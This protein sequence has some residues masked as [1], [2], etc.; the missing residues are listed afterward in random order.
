MPPRLRAHLESVGVAP[1][2]YAASWL[3]TTFSAEYPASFSAR[4]MDVVLSEKV[5]Q[6]LLK[7]A[8]ALLTA[9]E[10]ALLAAGD[11]EEALTFIKQ[12][13]P[14]WDEATLHDVLSEAF[15]KPWLPR[16]L[17][18]LATWEG[19]ETVGEAAERIGRANEAAAAAAA[20]E[21]GGGGGGGGGSGAGSPKQRLSDGGAPSPLPL[22]PPPCSPAAGL[23]SVGSASMRA[24]R[25]LSG[26]GA[27]SAGDGAA[28]SSS[29]ALPSPLAPAPATPPAPAAAA[30]GTAGAAAA[31][32]G[33]WLGGWEPFGEAPPSPSPQ[34][35]PAAA[36]PE[37]LWHEER[38]QHHHQHQHQHHLPAHSHGPSGL[39]PSASAPAI[40]GAAAAPAA[41]RA[42]AAAAARPA[43]VEPAAAGDCWG[44]FLS[45]PHVGLSD[46]APHPAAAAGP[47]SEWQ[48]EWEQAAP[49]AAAAAAP[50]SVPPQ[51]QQ[52]QQHQHQ[53]QRQ[54][55][56]QKTQQQAAADSLFEGL[57]VA[58]MADSSPG[59]K[60]ADLLL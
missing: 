17:A 9:G 7:V 13:M 12:G 23:R 49:T 57:F 18:L 43:S 39:G 37:W 47:G 36:A 3:M 6:A 8:V 33:D 54:Q 19:A 59:V 4:I 15:K 30:A 24:A 21:E 25:S 32:A 26:A 44:D 20:G 48:P 22:L 11:L 50:A 28:S 14:G 52:Q 58:A 2:L 42:A 46:S 31:A 45:S 1:S 53:H 29:S 10:R 40:A 35:P 5:D 38:H 55:H 41:P 27:A 56:A 51:Q 60:S 16:Q 34:P